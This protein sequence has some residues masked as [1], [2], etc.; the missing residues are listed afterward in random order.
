MNLDSQSLEPKRAWGTGDHHHAHISGGQEVQAGFCP[1]QT[2]LFLQGS[3]KALSSKPTRPHQ[4]RRAAARFLVSFPSPQFQETQGT[5]P[6]PPPPNFLP[7]CLIFPP[8]HSRPSSQPPAP[9]NSAPAPGSPAPALPPPL[10]PWPPLRTSGGQIEPRLEFTRLK[11]NSS[12]ILWEQCL[13]G[14]PQAHVHL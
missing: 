7:C 13:P 14:A 9:G 2:D 3:R 8:T 4:Q 5:A 1:L 12:Q 10:P 11:N 6:I